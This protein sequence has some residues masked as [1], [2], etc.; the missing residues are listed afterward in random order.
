MRAHTHSLTHTSC[1]LLH[2]RLCAI[3][4]SPRSMTYSGD[5]STVAQG[6]VRPSLHSTVCAYHCLPKQST[7]CEYVG[8]FQHNDKMNSLAYVGILYFAKL[9]WDK[10]LEVGLQV[11]KVIAYV[12]LLN[13][14]K[15]LS[16]RFIWRVCND[17]II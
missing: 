2:K 5:P 8:Y 1:L 9:F 17:N 7:I 14:V 16:I 13:K 12:I 15:Y 3:L 10:F 4:I 11:Q 6:A